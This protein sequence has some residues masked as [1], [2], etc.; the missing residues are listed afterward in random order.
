M[1]MRNI[2]KKDTINGVEISWCKQFVED[3]LGRQIIQIRI[4]SIIDPERNSPA[5]RVSGNGFEYI[6]PE[7][8]E[9]PEPD[10]LIVFGH[11]KYDRF[12]ITE[13]VEQYPE[14]ATTL[15]E[16][17]NLIEQRSK[18]AAALG[19][20]GGSAKTEKKVAASRENGKKGGR[21]K[22]ERG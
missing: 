15:T 9:Y 16:L 21:P 1:G 6:E 3:D 13:V 20:K 19:K 17:K 11:N 2:F 18:A 4:H 22:K 12:T 5:C 10:G 8:P 7:I 14:Y